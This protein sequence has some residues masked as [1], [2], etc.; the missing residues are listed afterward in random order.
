M[1]ID[2]FQD[3]VCPWCRIGKRNLQLALE[4]WQQSADS[5]ADPV[6]ITYHPF[7]L[8]AGIPPEG[9]PFRDYMHAKGGGQ[10]P[11]EQFFAAPRDAGRRVGLTFN[12]ERI[13]KAPN[14][15]LSHLLIEVTPETQRETMIDALYAAYFEFGR[16]IG[17]LDVLLAIAREIGLDAEAIRP[18]LADQTLQAQVFQ[19]TEDAQQLGISGVPFFVINDALA[20]SGAHPPESM[21]RVLRQAHAQSASKE[22]AGS[23]S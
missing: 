11:L 2:I 1:K 20:F 17:D 22:Q 4:Q 23:T 10:I 19:Q 8:N 16:D 9:Y 12:F 5:N 18:Q 21:M 13:E 15:L 14:T 7:F 3:T 6:T